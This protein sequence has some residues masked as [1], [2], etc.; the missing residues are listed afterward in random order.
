M[1]RVMH[2]TTDH[3]STIT[4]RDL[5]TVTGGTAKQNP[6]CQPPPCHQPPPRPQPP[7]HCGWPFPN[8]DHGAPFPTYHF[9]TGNWW[10]NGQTWQSANGSGNQ[11]AR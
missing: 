11:K 6:S 2:N 9:P 7:A 1:K 4:L 3:S 8:R 10:N 5:A